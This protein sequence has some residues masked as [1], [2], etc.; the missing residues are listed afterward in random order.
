MPAFPL[1]ISL[2]PQAR[3]HR[4]AQLS[5]QAGLPLPTFHA[6]PVTPTLLFPSAARMPVTWV[7]WVWRVISSQSQAGLSSAV[8]N[9]YWKAAWVAPGAGAEWGK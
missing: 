7:P 3:T 8:L 9:L 5:S 1:L 4:V 6:T 2:A